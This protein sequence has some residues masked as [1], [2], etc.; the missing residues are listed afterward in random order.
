MHSEYSPSLPLSVSLARPT[1]MVAPAIQ[2]VNIGDKV[3]FQCEAAGDG[4]IVVEWRLKDGE[5]LPEGAEQERNDL[6]I[7]SVDTSFTGIYA[8]FVSNL[9]GTDNATAELNVF[10][11]WN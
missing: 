3:T 1:V 7:S 6:V 9:A 2:S 11:E 10:C 5:D 8:C 4:E